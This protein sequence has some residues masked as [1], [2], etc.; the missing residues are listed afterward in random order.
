MLVRGGNS[1]VAHLLHEDDAFPIDH[2]G[3][4]ARFMDGRDQP[5]VSEDGVSV[6][7]Q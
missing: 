1:K 3:V 6:F 7:L 2:A 5:D 4:E